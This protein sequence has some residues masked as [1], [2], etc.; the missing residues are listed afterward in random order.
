MSMWMQLMWTG[1]DDG[2]G[3][4]SGSGMWRTQA[5]Q[6]GVSLHLMAACE[7]PVAMSCLCVSI[8]VW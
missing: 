2:A 4:E 5:Q 8:C 7:L 1:C 6:H 3:R